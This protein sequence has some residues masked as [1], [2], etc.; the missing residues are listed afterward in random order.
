MK[1]KREKTLLILS[2]IGV[3]ITLILSISLQ[4]NFTGLPETGS[5]TIGNQLSAD[6]THVSVSDKK[7]SLGRTYTNEAEFDVQNLS[8]LS[9]LALNLKIQYKS[10]DGWIQVVLITDKG[11][12][13]MI[14]EDLAIFHLDNLVTI[15][16]VCQET[17]LLNTQNAQK[18]KILVGN[19]DL[20]INS[21]S[22]NDVDKAV[23]NYEAQAE[24]LVNKQQDYRIQQIK[25]FIKT[26]NLPWTAGATKFSQASYNERIQQDTHQQVTASSILYNYYQGGVFTL[27]AP[28]KK[29]A[30]TSSDN[31]EMPP[32]SFDW[33]N[34]HGEDW[35]T[36]VKA[37]GYMPSCGAFSRVAILE[38]NIN[39]YYNQHFNLDLSEQMAFDYGVNGYEQSRIDGWIVPNYSQDP[40]CNLDWN[41]K[42]NW[43]LALNGI[44]D[45]RCDPYVGWGGFDPILSDGGGGTICSNWL[46]RVWRSANWKQ[47]FTPYYSDKFREGW[48]YTDY[49]NNASCL[50]RKNNSYVP[51]EDEFKK[52]LIKNGPMATWYPALTHSMMLVGYGTTNDW[53]TQ[54]V[55]QLNSANSYNAMSQYSLCAQ[56]GCISTPCDQDHVG[57]KYCIINTPVQCTMDTPNNY[58][59]K[60]IR[61]G[62]ICTGNIGCEASQVGQSICAN[63]Q[64]MQCVN[65]NGYI[66]WQTTSTCAGKCINNEC[67]TDANY[68]FKSGDVTCSR[69]A[70]DGAYVVSK[71]TPGFAGQDYWIFKSSS[72]S[73]TPGWGDAG[74]IKIIAPYDT[75]ANTAV[76]TGPF[77]PPQ[78]TAYW[79]A[80]FNNQVTC[81]DKDQDHY[82]NWGISAT[83]PASCGTLQ[84]KPEKDCDDSNPDLAGYDAGMKC[85]Q[86][87]DVSLTS[88]A[89]SKGAITIGTNLNYNISV[90]NNTLQSQSLTAQI[91]LPTGTKFI[92]A[93]GSATN[94]LL[95]NTVQLDCKIAIA[96]KTRSIIQIVV[97]PLLPT[98]LSLNSQINNSKY[99][100]K[101]IQ[102]LAN[103][104]LYVSGSTG[105]DIKGT[106]AQERP[107]KTITKALSKATSGTLIKITSGTYYENLSI[108]QGVSLIGGFKPFIWKQ[109]RGDTSYQT[110]LLKTQSKTSTQ[111]TP[112]VRITGDQVLISDI[113]FESTVLY[114]QAI[115]INANSSQYLDLE[116]NYFRNFAIPKNTGSVLTMNNCVVCVE[117]S[118]SITIRN[119][120]FYMN[121]AS[122]IKFAQNTSVVLTNNLFAENT[123]LAI[124]FITPSTNYINFNL[125]WR[126]SRGKEF[127][128]STH[129]LNVD[130]QFASTT[131]LSITRGSPCVN[132]GFNNKTIG[133][134]QPIQIIIKQ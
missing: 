119:N 15:N 61:D 107:Y 132:A 56:Q 64:I 93:T 101:E 38:S 35:T 75:L 98:V 77:T 91:L 17:C 42:V 102:A 123:G 43:S 121:S 83:M 30:S 51:S 25:S 74:F 65:D 8:K 88:S 89:D 81:T 37:Q 117:T 49:P 33:R 109:N 73:S 60:V 59:N 110:R 3:V 87:V 50:W 11:Q 27:T 71:Y 125:L 127:T 6:F 131:T 32:A 90:S 63:E 48:K 115:Y 97:T 39:L 78:N 5:S 128:E 44:A 9:S 46:R 67:V 28:I 114:E 24:N 126:T 26:N 84:C 62:S 86:N 92:S 69:N 23:G 2:L 54:Q 82:C 66:T 94:C 129:T 41:S 104:Q 13:L 19:A 76:F 105:S 85:K 22:Y 120:T 29:V 99:V 112:L 16:N 122:N 113:F 133:A 34:V 21:I 79:P 118:K 124:Q 103:K 111:L 58:S 53:T 57:A 130:P 80:N 55:C 18:I 68:Q 10:S 52:L 134:F 108:S 47:Y 96:S 106:G 7:F 116:Y 72:G 40:T 20:T 36:G 70:Q 1:F 45:E 31:S 14:F 100:S 4:L 12:Q 95:T